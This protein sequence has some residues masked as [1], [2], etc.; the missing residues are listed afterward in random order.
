MHL[1]TL[2]VLHVQTPVSAK[3]FLGMKVTVTTTQQTLQVFVAAK[4]TTT[5]LTPTAV[6][7]AQVSKLRLI[8]DNWVNKFYSIL[9]VADI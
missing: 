9:T 1:T 2:Q 3:K 7:V 6:R 8:A 5:W 4:I